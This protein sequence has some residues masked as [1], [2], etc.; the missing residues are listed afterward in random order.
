MSLPRAEMAGGIDLPMVQIKLAEK[1]LS[2]D[3][4]VEAHNDATDKSFVHC[5][6]RI[7]ILQMPCRQDH[8]SCA[9]SLEFW[10]LS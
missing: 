8:H 10:A 2:K 9:R 5:T 1:R 4:I 7:S 3:R 6:S